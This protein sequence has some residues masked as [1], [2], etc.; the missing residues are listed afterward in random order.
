[1]SAMRPTEKKRFMRDLPSI[2]SL[3]AGLAAGLS[4]ALALLL[5][6]M[7]L[8][9]ETAEA[10]GAAAASG[11]LLFWEYIPVGFRHILPLGIDHILFV[12]GLFFLSTK[13]K[14]LLWQV[15][16][17]TVAHSITLA[18]AATGYVSAP[19]QIIEPLIAASI[20]FVAIENIVIQRLTPW[21]PVIVFAFGLLHGL[22]F[23]SVLGEFG[24]PQGGL[25]PA[26]LGFNVGVELGQLTVIAAAFLAVGLWFGGKAWYRRLIATPASVAIAVTGT[27][28]VV[29]RVAG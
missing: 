29:Q 1:M 2:P 4:M 14:P 5:P 23:A 16:A 24:L 21:R 27:I 8:A 18:L 22:G 20:T 26:I 12:L 17:F 9:Q 10:T 7:G 11:G 3:K 19:P 13:L 28:W 15:T 6:S 25:L